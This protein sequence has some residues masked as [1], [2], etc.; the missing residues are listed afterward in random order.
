MK[1][2]IAERHNDYEGFDILGIFIKKE[3]AETCCSEDV[4]NKGLP[5]GDEYEVTKHKVQS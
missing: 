4:D 2:Y 1:I 3:D 5:K